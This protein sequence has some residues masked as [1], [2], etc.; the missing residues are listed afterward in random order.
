MHPLVWIASMTKAEKLTVG[1]LV[2]MIGLIG[3]TLV[4]GALR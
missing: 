1:Y 3:T 2:Y 4:L